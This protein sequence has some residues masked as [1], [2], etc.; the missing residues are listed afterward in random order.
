MPRWKKIRLVRIFPLAVCRFSPPRKSSKP[1]VSKYPTIYLE[2]LDGIFSKSI[3]FIY[4]F[5]ADTLEN[6]LKVA[7][8]ISI[9]RYRSVSKSRVRC[10]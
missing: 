6:D 10:E 8:L 5:F 2:N 3:Y 7:D 4:I 9:G 1:K